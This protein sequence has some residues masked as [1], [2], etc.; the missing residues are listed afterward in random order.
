MIF[1]EVGNVFVNI[2]L[3]RRS[4]EPRGDVGICC[5]EKTSLG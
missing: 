4:H 3:C 1:S 5:R 2:M